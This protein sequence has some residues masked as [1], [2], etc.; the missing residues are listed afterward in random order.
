MISCAPGF[1]GWK[2]RRSRTWRRS[3]ARLE[4]QG[5]AAVAGTSVQPQKIA[6]KRAA[7]MRY[8]GQEHAVTVD[9]PLAVFT[10]RD[11]KAIKRLFDQMHEL[12]YGTC[13]PAEPAEIVSL[14]STVSGIMRKPPQAKITR[15]R[16]IPPKA[17]FTRQAARGLG[18]ARRLSPRPRPIGAPN[19]WPATRSKAR[20]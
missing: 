2:T 9:I 15:G 6:F 11:G 8:V 17:A 4:E 14:R 3:I 16:A 10:R 7:D 19:C 20:R 5:R 13:A 18:R 1:A 12:R